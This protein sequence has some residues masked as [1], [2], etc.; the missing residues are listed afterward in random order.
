MLDA[1]IMDHNLR[2]VNLDPSDEL[3]IHRFNQQML[4]RNLSR[5]TIANYAGMLAR[6]ARWLGEAGRGTVTGAAEE[7]IE[8]YLLH[9]RRS[10]ADSSYATVF[11]RLATFYKWAADKEMIEGRSPMAGMSRPQ[12][13]VREVPL[14]DIADLARIVKACEGRKGKRGKDEEFRDRRDMALCR[15]LLCTGTPRAEALANLTLAQVDLRHDR[16]TVMDKGSKERTIP[17][18]GK[19]AHALM[20]YLRARAK[21][22]AAKTCDRLFLGNRGPM[23]RDGIYQVVAARCEQAG[24]PV[25]SPHK[26]RHYSAH[27][28]FRAG[29]S[30]GDA[31]Y[32]F[33]WK[34]RAMATRYA[35]AAQAS[36][37]QEHAAALGLGDLVA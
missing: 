10:Y 15:L 30:E 5:N 4:R 13:E 6:L 18:T 20:L 14:P 2:A 17:L 32:L 12:G 27:E 21:Q 8:A 22:K 25:I 19:A 28:W 1:D 9:V 35:S 24:V 7:D 36:R 11:T 29:G 31:M 23:T 37:A 3:V 33:G 34:S 26:W 16:M